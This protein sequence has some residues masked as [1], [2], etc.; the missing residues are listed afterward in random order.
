MLYNN[1]V[2]IFN[3]MFLYQPEILIEVFKLYM[4]AF[5]FIKIK[6]STCM[7]VHE[8]PLKGQ[9]QCNKFLQ[10]KS[11]IIINYVHNNKQSK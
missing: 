1:L 7:F 2:K 3:D 8:E 6:I 9:L 10:I 4:M 5:Y 11:N